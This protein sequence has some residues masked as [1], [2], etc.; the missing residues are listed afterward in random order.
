MACERTF[1]KNRL[2]ACDNAA[3]IKCKSS[4]ARSLTPLFG[5]TAQNRRNRSVSGNSI[6]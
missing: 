3:Q 4:P 6:P 2:L 1:V 5:F